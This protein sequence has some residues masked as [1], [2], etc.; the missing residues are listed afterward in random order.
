MN[1][2]GQASPPP[3]PPQQQQQQA[4]GAVNQQT[5]QHQADIGQTTNATPG[6]LASYETIA[7]D[8]GV[9]NDTS[10]YRRI[11]IREKTIFVQLNFV[12]LDSFGY[13]R[14]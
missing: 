3:P 13:G 14:Y 12:I 11:R 8:Q 10:K 7:Q 4:A 9:G 1:N 6:S 2:Q 5:Q